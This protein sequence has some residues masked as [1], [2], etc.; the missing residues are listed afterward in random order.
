MT[1]IKQKNIKEKKE[2]KTNKARKE[3]PSIRKASTK[4]KL[5]TKLLTKLCMGLLIG[6]FTFSIHADGATEAIRLQ[7]TIDETSAPILT[8]APILT[9]L[10][11]AGQNLKEWHDLM[12]NRTF[13]FIE[14]MYYDGIMMAQDLATTEQYAKNIH[15]LQ[16]TIN[17]YKFMVV[18]ITDVLLEAT[19]TEPDNKKSYYSIIDYLEQMLLKQTNKIPEN[20]NKWA[21]GLLERSILIVNSIAQKII[22][23]YKKLSQTS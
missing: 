1:T 9:D 4:L 17:Q 21:Q 18:V 7:N 3:L 13:P 8:E 2:K 5:L 15:L 11:A 16:T 19:K 14:S 20:G 12:I 10:N 22:N 6:F 23:N